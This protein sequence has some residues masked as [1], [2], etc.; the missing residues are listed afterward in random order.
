MSFNI[1]NIV[2]DLFED[3][4]DSDEVSSMA[5]LEDKTLDEEFHANQQEIMEPMDIQFE[6]VNHHFKDIN[7][8][9]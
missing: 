1:R 7:L 8:L 9:I 3:E 5:S 4:D 2:P 6:E